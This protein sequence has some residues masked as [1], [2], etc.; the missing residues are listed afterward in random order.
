[1]V[2]G[3]NPSIRYAGS[4][5]GLDSA[6]GDSLLGAVSD[7]VEAIDA[8]GMVDGTAGGIDARRFAVAGAQAALHTLA[9]I[10]PHPEELISADRP[11][12]RTHRADDVA[13]DA[14]PEP[15][16]EHHQDEGHAGGD[17]QG[18]GTSA[19][20]AADDA[21]VGAVGP[22]KGDDH[23][24]VE[25]DGSYDQGE[26]RVTYPPA[27]LAPAEAL[28]YGLPLGEPLAEPAAEPDDDVL[29]HAQRADDGAI[30]AAGKESD[31]QD[32]PGHGDVAERGAPDEPHG[33]REELEFCHPAPPVVPYADEQQRDTDEEQRCE[34][35]SDFT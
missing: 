14:P 6:E 35:D 13:P 25:D 9:F 12:Q 18:S 23:L 8:T 28:A 11:E 4:G 29:H 21:A 15:C 1:M 24:E 32:A 10:D 26:D 2:L 19:H 3:D 33:G 34:C 7:A 16:A 30:D 20:N 5:F 17:Q 27:L 22:E 31:Q